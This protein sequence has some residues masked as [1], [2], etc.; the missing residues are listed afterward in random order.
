M[1]SIQIS[2][3]MRFQNKELVT[4]VGGTDGLNCMNEKEV[5]KKKIIKA[6]DTLD[7]SELEV[8]LEWIPALKNFKSE[9]LTDEEFKEYLGETKKNNE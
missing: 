8:M 7:R 6:L 1:Q 4:I 3:A 5:L 9:K 2:L